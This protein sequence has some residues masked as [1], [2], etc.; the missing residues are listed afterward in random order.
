[1]TDI[2]P[3]REVERDKILEA[4][5]R[6]GGSKKK[7]AEALGINARTIFKRLHE[8]GLFEKYAKTKPRR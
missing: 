6:F 2:K 4:L 3:L 8:Y 5:E 1:M 7:A